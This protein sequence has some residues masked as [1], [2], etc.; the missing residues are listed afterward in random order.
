MQ[1][2]PTASTTRSGRSAATC[3]ASSSAS[4][5]ATSSSSTCKNHPDNKMPHNIDLHAVNGP[6]RRRG[7]ARSRRPATSRSF[8][9][10]RAEP[11][12]LRLPLRDRAGRHAHR[13][14]HVRHD[15]RRAEGRPAEGRPRVLRDAGRV[16]HEGHVRRAAGCS[17]STWT[18]ASTRSPTYVVFNGSVGALAGDERAAGEGRRARS[19][20]R[21][22]RRPEPR[23]ARSTSSARSSTTCTPKAARRETRQRADD[24]H[25]R[26]RRRDRG[27]RRSTSRARTSSSTTRSSAPSTKARW[28]SSK[29]TGAENKDV[30]SGKLS[31]TVYLPEGSR[32]RNID[33]ARRAAADGEDEGRAREARQ[34]GLQTNCAACH[35]LN[36]EGI[37]QAFPPLAKSDYLNADEK[38]AIEVVTGGLS[39]KVTV[40]GKEFNSVMPAWQLAA[41][42]TSRTCSR[43]STRRGATRAWR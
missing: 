27:V 22:Q 17:R 12:P 28:R 3:P 7:D 40:N 19:P 1:R 11:G 42:R 4:A 9:F 37:P 24:D 33:V 26:R 35:Q 6:G 16:L 20:L 43:T 21:R 39:G 25:S 32:M 2:S 14:R 31:D 15:P 36:G 13:Q 34:S 18:R 5:R 10:T 38:R 23:L 30:Y 29:S 41:T 8:T